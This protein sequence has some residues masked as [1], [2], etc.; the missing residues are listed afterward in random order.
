[1]TAYL[2]TAL[3]R[4]G[5][6]VI[7][8]LLLSVSLA[9]STAQAQQLVM[10]IDIDGA[11]FEQGLV[12]VTGTVTCSDPTDFTDVSVT[13][14]QP[15]GRFR[16]IEGFA[17]DSLGPCVEQLSFSLPVAPGSGRFKQGDAFV[18]ADTFACNEVSCDGDNTVEVVKLTK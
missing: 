14:R 16:S 5:F 15:V 18:F 6:A 2:P 12:M 3:Q 7:V 9:I 10:Q 1:M 8:G 4:T 17:S 13:V 11:T